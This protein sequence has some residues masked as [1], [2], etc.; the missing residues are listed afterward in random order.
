M[1]CSLAEPAVRC[2]ASR[3]VGEEEFVIL[4]LLV[5]TSFRGSAISCE[6]LPLSFIGRRQRRTEVLSGVTA[7]PKGALRQHEQKC[8]RSKGAKMSAAILGESGGSCLRRGQARRHLT[9]D[10]LIV[11]GYR[12]LHMNTSASYAGFLRQPLEL[13]LKKRFQLLRCQ[14]GNRKSRGLAVIGF[15]LHAVWGFRL[16]RFRSHA[17]PLFLSDENG[18]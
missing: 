12:P 17:T 10:L 9:E 6:L 3:P 13:T 14:D 18:R 2:V 1:S 15:D 16:L 4:A 11:S 8:K 5:A 7:K